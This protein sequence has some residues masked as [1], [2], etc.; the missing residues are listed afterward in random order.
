MNMKGYPMEDISNSLVAQIG[1]IVL[2]IAAYSE[3]FGA[4][5]AEITEAVIQGFRVQ[6]RFKPGINIVTSV[7]VA[8]IIGSVLAIYASWQVIPIAALAG[9]MASTKAAEV[10]DAKTIGKKE[11]SPAETGEIP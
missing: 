6:K 2:A 10:H 3:A 9:L 7:L 4:R 8:S 1:F 5:Q 11:A